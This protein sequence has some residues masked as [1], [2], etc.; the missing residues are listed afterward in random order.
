MKE[1]ESK[2]FFEK[3]GGKEKEISRKDLVYKAGDS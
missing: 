1:A 2:L 3:L